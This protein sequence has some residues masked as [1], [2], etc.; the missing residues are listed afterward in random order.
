[1]EGTVHCIGIDVDNQSEI[2]RLANVDTVP[3][4]Q[5]LHNEELVELW[6]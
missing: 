5:L 4:I 3:T 1:M 2:A 6:V